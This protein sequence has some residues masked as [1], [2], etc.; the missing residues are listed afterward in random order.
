MILYI[1]ETTKFYKI[2]L[3]KGG[4]LADLTL[5]KKE[6][7]QGGDWVVGK[8]S[9]V[10]RQQHLAFV[11]IN[12][13][14][15]GLL[16]IKKGDTINPGDLLLLEVLYPAQ[17]SKGAKLSQNI[18]LTDGTIAIERGEGISASRRLGKDFLK[19]CPLEEPKDYH[20]ILRQGAKRLSL[21]ELQ[22]RMEE[23]KQVFEKRLKLAKDC[24]EVQTIARNWY[25]LKEMV[26]EQNEEL[27]QV[28]VNGPELFKGIRELFPTVDRKKSRSPYLFYEADLKGQVEELAAR[29]VFVSQGNLI[30]EE[31]EA[32]NVID[33]NTAKNLRQE[34]LN[35][36][37][38]AW[39]ESLR[40]IKLRNL[41]GI[42]LIDFP[43]LSSKGEE[44]KLEEQIRRD[45]AQESIST[46]SFPMTELGL[47]Q[48]S[49]RRVGPSLSQSLFQNPV[50]QSSLYTLDELV[51]AIVAELSQENRFR[52]IDLVLRKDYQSVIR[53]EAFEEELTRHCPFLQWNLSFQPM[54]SHF[55]WQEVQR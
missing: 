17:G 48:I 25:F 7:H 52:A 10:L 15:E 28:Q 27:T 2:A 41:S 16:S 4:K 55:R 23:L 29:K 54:S 6:G 45:C 39:Q 37:L 49:R 9:Q 5:R 33:V 14:Q 42:I 43:N 21:V 44:K 1:E 38:Q 26:Q 50:F 22:G 31:T 51:S 47:I 12:E 19:K 30:I 35:F 34:T 36:C 53:V 3:T 46:K 11:D 32:M 8:V 13:A 18:S 20:V 40:Q 24:Q